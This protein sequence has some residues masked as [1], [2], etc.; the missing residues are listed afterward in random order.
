MA[1]KVINPYQHDCEN[2][3]WVG[4]TPCRNASNGWGNMY[5]C[6]GVAGG[7]AGTVIIRYGNEPHEYLSM[8]VGVCQKGGLGIAE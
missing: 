1:R 6:Q 5:F 4:W 2:C 7:R 8:P 3:V